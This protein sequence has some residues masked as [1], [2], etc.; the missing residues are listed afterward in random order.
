MRV[1]VYGSRPNGHARV[2]IEELLASEDFDVVGLID[3][4]PANVGR[5]IAGLSVIGSGADLPRLVQ[6]GVEGLVLGFGATEGRAGIVAAAEA[7]G[8]ALPSLV[9]P[10]AHVA[11]SAAIASGVQVLAHAIIGPGAQIGRGALVNSG[12]II[13]HDAVVCDFAVIDPGAVLA[14]R[15]IIG[16]SVEIGTGAVVLPDIDIGAHAVVGAGAVVTR[17]VRRGETVVGVPARRMRR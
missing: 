16:E 7:A 8:L 11:S 2:V 5:R 17:P 9:H 10:S 1:A 14:G 4:Q 13:E 15:A 3:D 6:D 12:A